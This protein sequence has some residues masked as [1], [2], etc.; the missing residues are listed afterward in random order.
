MDFHTSEQWTFDMIHC[1]LRLPDPIAKVN[2]VR[3]CGWEKIKI[4]P[5][6]R[7]L[8]VLIVNPPVVDLSEFSMEF[9]V[10]TAR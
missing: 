8:C 3:R 4:A 9:T 10:Y 5:A 7:N 1:Y 6:L 2:A